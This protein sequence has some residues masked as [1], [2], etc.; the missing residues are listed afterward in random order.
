MVD[1]FTIP[2]QKYLPY[3]RAI[4]LHDTTQQIAKTL[5]IKYHTVRYNLKLL[6]DNQLITH[7]ID[8]GMK[9]YSLTQWGIEYLTRGSLGDE[10]LKLW[11]KHRIELSFSIVQ[12]PKGWTKRKP[13][14]CR[15]IGDRVRQSRLNNNTIEFLDLF[16][17]TWKFS[18]DKV[19]FF[20]NNIY[21]ASPEEV[22]T[23]AI[24]E[25]NKVMDRVIE[26]LDEIGVKIAVPGTVTPLRRDSTIT[27]SQT[28]EYAREHDEMAEL[29]SPH[30][31]DVID[32]QGE[33]RAK[34]DSS[35]GFPEFDLVHKQKSPE[36]AKRYGTWCSDFLDRK[37]D[38]W[39]TQNTVKAVAKTLSV[40]SDTQTQIARNQEDITS[41]LSNLQQL[42]VKQITSS[43][44][45]T[46]EG[47]GNC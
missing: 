39:K 33:V 24:R 32:Q 27:Y 20:L 41:A 31:V 3:L 43:S 30:K 17:L 40:F 2:F 1:S 10:N 45:D 44:P 8:K 6:E 38:P 19:N 12:R 11:R 35:K 26:K 42:T 14:Y 22:D 9:F 47:V 36:D 18:N 21:G 28:A 15:L 46:G 23:K 13:T 29:L 25:I 4:R 37:L 7:I 34:I 16:D 5:G